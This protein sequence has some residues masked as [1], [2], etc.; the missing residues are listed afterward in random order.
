MFPERLR[1]CCPCSRHPPPKVS[2]RSANLPPWRS[3]GGFPR[4]RASGTITSGGAIL[5]RRV[6]GHRVRPISRRQNCRSRHRCHPAAARNPV[7]GRRGGTA[8]AAAA[9]LS[10]LISPQYPLSVLRQ[11]L[12]QPLCR[13]LLEYPPPFHCSRVAGRNFFRILSPGRPPDTGRISALVE[14]NLGCDLKTAPV[15]PVAAGTDCSRDIVLVMDR[16]NWKDLLEYDPAAASKA[17][18]LGVFD[19]TETVEIE[20]PYMMADPNQCWHAS[21]GL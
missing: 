16:R 21:G 14:E 5:F 10:R 2:T 1:T 7:A 6:S 17:Y 9:R 12:P 20:D 4:T 13:S 19:K 15:A 3:F 8:K 18:F 11:Y